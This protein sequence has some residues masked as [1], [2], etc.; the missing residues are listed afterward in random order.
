MKIYI[1]DADGT[2]SPQRNGSAG[3]FHYR[4]LPNVKEKLSGLIQRGDVCCIAS[5]QS[6]RRSVR[7]IENQ[8]KW[9][10]AELGISPEA[11]FWETDSGR[12]KPH[13]FMLNKIKRLYPGYDV[14]FI[15]D[16]PSDEDAARAADMPFYYAQLFFGG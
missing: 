7:D 11:C 2:L 1:F 10:C 5:N 9:L 14:A 4:L 15:G 3:E 12:K 6:S 13:P 16:R 8:M